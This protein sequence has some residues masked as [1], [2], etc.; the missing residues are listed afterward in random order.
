MTFW[1][2]TDQEFDEFLAVIG[3]TKFSSYRE[4]SKTGAKIGPKNG[5][6]ITRFSLL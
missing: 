4:D 5:A 2:I 6:K 3:Y 1:P